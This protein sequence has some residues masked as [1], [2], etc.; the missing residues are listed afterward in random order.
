MGTAKTFGNCLLY[1]LLP[2]A[3]TF[4]T[5][6]DVR[7]PRHQTAFAGVGDTLGNGATKR[8]RPPETYDVTRRREDGGSKHGESTYGFVFCLALRINVDQNRLILV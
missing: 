8:H 6:S 5:F 3:L 4:H 7:V 1:P 2:L